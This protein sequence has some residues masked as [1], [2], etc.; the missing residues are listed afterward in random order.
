MVYEEGKHSGALPI[1]G[2]NT[3]LDPAAAHGGYKAPASITRA[4]K[5]DKEGQIN[6]LLAFQ[7]RN[8]SKAD[9]AL[10]KLQKAA[11]TGGNIFTELMETVKYASLGEITGALYEIGGRYRRNM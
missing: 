8:R 9:A 4:S 10:K 7:K 1:V 3:F 2:V 6:N 11:Q 5:A